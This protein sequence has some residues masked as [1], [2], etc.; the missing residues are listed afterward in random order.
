VRQQIGKH[1]SLSFDDNAGLD[2]YRNTK[3]RPGVRE[4]VKFA[5][6]A[7]R[8]HRPG[9]IT[10]QRGVEFAAGECRIERARVHAR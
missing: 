2:R 5:A 9:K 3:H 7:A 10:E 8:I 4:R 6:L 1:E